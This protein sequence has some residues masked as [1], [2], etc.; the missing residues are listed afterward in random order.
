[1]THSLLPQIWRKSQLQKISIIAQSLSY[2]LSDIGETK[3]QS[4]IL[5]D[6]VETKAQEQI[7][8]DIVETKTQWQIAKED[9][10]RKE[11]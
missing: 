1:M 11:F 7:L 9:V 3:T 10:S 4:Q 5:S 2:T 6:I 8:S